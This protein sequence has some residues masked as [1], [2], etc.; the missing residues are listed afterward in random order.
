MRAFLLIVCYFILFISV[1]SIFNARNILLKYSITVSKRNKA[2]SVFKGIFTLIA[3]VSLT[4]IMY[5]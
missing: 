3:V 1:I 2:V 4:F 5:I